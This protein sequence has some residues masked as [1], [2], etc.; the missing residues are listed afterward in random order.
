[1]SGEVARPNYYIL[2]T[3]KTSPVDVPRPPHPK[4]VLDT[5]ALAKGRSDVHAEPTSLLLQVI[6]YY[7]HICI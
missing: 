2:S 7:K 5:G 1:M 6:K 3:F 4:R